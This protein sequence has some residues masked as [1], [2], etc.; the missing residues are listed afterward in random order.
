[1]NFH[2]QFAHGDLGIYRN[3]P[4]QFT[5]GAIASI[6]RESTEQAAKASFSS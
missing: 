6:A 1:M 5:E 4:R 3:F 2:A